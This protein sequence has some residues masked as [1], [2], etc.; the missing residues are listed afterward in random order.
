MFLLIANSGGVWMMAGE[1][2][3]SHW[4]GLQL[5]WLLHWQLKSIWKPGNYDSYL[6]F[7]LEQL[8][9]S[10]LFVLGDPPGAVH[11]PEA[12]PA[13]VLVENDVLELDFHEGGAGRRHLIMTLSTNL[14]T[15]EDGEKSASLNSPGTSLVTHLRN[16]L[17][18]SRTQWRPR[19]RW[20]TVRVASARHPRF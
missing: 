19:C 12:A 2:T 10:H 20:L 6:V 18:S 14:A 8:F 17:G 4:I 16:R 13:T 11:A 3:T 15:G 9:H 7:N 1:V 5:T